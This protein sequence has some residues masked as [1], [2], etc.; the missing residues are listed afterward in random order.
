MIAK[1]WSDIQLF[2]EIEAVAPDLPYMAMNLEKD[3]STDLVRSMNIRYLGTE[4]MFSNENSQLCQQAYVEHMHEMGYLVWCNAIVFNPNVIF[5]AGH[6][7]LGNGMKHGAGL[8][9]WGMI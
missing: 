5:A 3:T 9:T 6:N 8:R 2:R 4:V 7:R 1:T